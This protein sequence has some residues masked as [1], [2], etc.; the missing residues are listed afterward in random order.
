MRTLFR[1]ERFVSVLVD[2]GNVVPVEKQLARHLADLSVRMDPFGGVT[3]KITIIVN[4][5]DAL[6]AGSESLRL[7]RQGIGEYITS[8]PFVDEIQLVLP[9]DPHWSALGWTPSP[10]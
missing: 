4:T 5:D 9:V 6:E 7:I 1:V 8:A 2:V 3:K 10:T